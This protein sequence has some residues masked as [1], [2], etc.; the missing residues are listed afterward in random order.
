MA[1]NP[2]NDADSGASVAAGDGGA[3]MTTKSGC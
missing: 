2:G 3:V 1:S